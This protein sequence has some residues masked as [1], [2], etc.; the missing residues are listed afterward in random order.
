M[1]ERGQLRAD[2]DGARRYTDRTLLRP[3]AIGLSLFLATGVLSLVAGPERA[4]G[5]ATPLGLI[6]GA[7]RI[8]GTASAHS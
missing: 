8:R 1:I 4:G 3:S 5:P 6:A 2:A 7:L